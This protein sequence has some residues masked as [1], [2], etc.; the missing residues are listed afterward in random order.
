MRR[1]LLPALTVLLL[2]PASASAHTWAIQYAAQPG[3]KA[4]RALVRG[5]QRLGLEPR[6]F[7]ALPMLLVSGPQRTVRRAARLRGARY[8]HRV[9]HK[10][11]F[12]LDRSVP[13]IFRGPAQPFYDK[14]DDG[15]G[16]VVA[17]V[18]TGIDGTHPDLMD[19]VIENVEIAMDSGDF[20]P[21]LNPGL[22]S[23]VVAQECPTV[24]NTDAFGHGT[25][26]AGIVA[27]TG[28]ASSGLERGVAPGTKLVGVSISQSGLTLEF[29]ALA[30]LDY[31][32]SHPELGITAVNNSWGLNEPEFDPTT[33]VNQATK[34][35]HDKGVTVVFAAGNSGENAAPRDDQPVS[36]SDCTPES[37]NCVINT[38]SVAPWVVSVAAGANVRDGGLGVQRLADFSSRGDDVVHDVK[39]V[40]TSFMPDITAPGS[41]ILSAADSASAIGNP[42]VCA[43]VG[44]PARCTLDRD[45][46]TAP[47]Y[48]ALN[49][50]S[51][52]APHVA[53]AIAVLQGRAKR[54]LHRALTPDEMLVVLTS[55]AAHMTEKDGTS[56]LCEQNFPAVTN[57]PCGDPGTTFT[58][59]PY[60]PWQVGAGYLDMPA[61]LAAVDA[62]AAPP[63]PVATPAPASAA[64][65]AAVAKPKPKPKPKAKPRKR[66]CKP[67]KA[68]R[69]RKRKTCPKKRPAPKKS[70]SRR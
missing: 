59:E 40:L 21:G 29:Y 44:D 43:G 23:A 68:T 66:T 15:S 20:A 41:S 54:S 61:A 67:R 53:G 58:G 3:V 42:A 45:P 6:G 5:L 9:D 70:S 18:D 26:V 55:S 63:A 11:E 35:L 14:G 37:E 28:A 39:G 51:M 12:F 4:P 7:Q 50:T 64:K 10:V 62:L 22:P 34:M 8:V 33:P 60:Q 69:N 65:P 13:L 36:A 25:H 32:L 17:V 31:V 48:T 27:G 56:D 47:F 1:V 52:A 38:N 16:E 30:G 49:G 19:R 57:R 46:T 24:C 2:L